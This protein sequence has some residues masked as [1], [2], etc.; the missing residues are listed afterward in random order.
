MRE[1]S[2]PPLPRI[3]IS[4]CLLGREV[5]FDGGHKRD[6]FLTDEAAPFVEFVPFCPEVGIG[7]GIPRPTI[8]L[9][10]V[11]GE[12]RLRSSR[13]PDNDYSDA[14]RDYGL[15]QVESL[16]DCCGF[17]VKK[18]SPSC[19][20]ERVPV[21]INEA[22]YRSRDGVGIFAATLRQQLP[23][24][25]ME[26]EGRL[27]DPQLREAFLE[28]IYALHRWHQLE[29]PERNVEGF[30]QFHSRHKLMLMGRGDRYYREL[31]QLVAGVTVAELAQ[32]RT[33][34][35]TRFM[36]VLALGASRGRTINVLQHIMGFFK[37][38]LSADDKQELLTL[39]SAY[40]MQ[41]TPLITPI[42]LLRHHLRHHPDP[43]LAG[44]YFLT[45]YPEGLSPHARV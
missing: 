6:R 5:R 37:E 43:W 11:E 26:E 29:D 25:P 22:G 19:G 2:S 39:F 34:Y 8:Q 44:Q 38:Q 36:E 33:R 35:I 15:A 10:M 1:T 32:R 40:R 23:L 30:I 7:L 16:A 27:H 45:P 28:R 4:A 18:G 13:Q 31:G 24:I 12:V 21:V 41:R 42:T 17:V 9:R 14:M 3:G 20:M